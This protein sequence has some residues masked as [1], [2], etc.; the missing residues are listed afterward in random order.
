MIRKCI[1]LYPKLGYQ[2]L[3][4]AKVWVEAYPSAHQCHHCLFSLDTTYWLVLSDLDV[5]ARIF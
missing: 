5:G 1:R 4:V 2:V 3:D